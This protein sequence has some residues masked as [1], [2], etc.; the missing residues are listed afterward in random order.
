MFFYRIAY[1]HTSLSGESEH[2][3]D[4][5][6]VQRGNMAFS[7]GSNGS[8]P[9]WEACKPSGQRHGP[10]CS[11]RITQGHQIPKKRVGLLRVSIASPLA[12]RPTHRHINASR[13]APHCLRFSACL[14]ATVPRS[15]S[16]QRR[17][18][19][20]GSRRLA[21]ALGVRALFRPQRSIVRFF[22][23]AARPPSS[24]MG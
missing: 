17:S 20:P 21:D 16:G 6:P 7:L 9:L 11:L 4:T 19:S 1:D 3:A 22:L 5:A 15:C 8:P 10:R 13:R 12:I 24:R 23:A 18:A 14:A 2:R